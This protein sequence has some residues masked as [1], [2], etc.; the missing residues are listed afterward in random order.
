MSN[1]FFPSSPPLENR[2]RSS[3][4]D[5]QNPQCPICQV[6]LNGQ[7]MFTHIQ[8]ELDTIERN[9]QQ[10]RYSMRRSTHLANTHHKVCHHLFERYK[11]IFIDCVYIRI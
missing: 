6:S 3:T 7:D 11:F 4:I 9:R 1:S 2:C 8:H 10:Q 5:L